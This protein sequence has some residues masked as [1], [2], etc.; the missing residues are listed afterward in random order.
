[1]NWTIIWVVWLIDIG[2]RSQI[3][4]WDLIYASV[5]IRSFSQA[6]VLRLCKF[7]LGSSIIPVI[8]LNIT[9]FHVYDQKRTLLN[10]LWGL[11]WLLR[12]PEGG[13][14]CA[15]LLESFLCMSIY[16]SIV[17]VIIKCY[18][19]MLASRCPKSA[20]RMIFSLHYG[21][22]NSPRDSSG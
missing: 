21:Y 14:I 10:F 13:H 3:S 20:T 16:A 15:S 19:W 18:Y 7:A 9:S 5:A 8:R 1:M 6:W 12:G 4:R 22:R 17:I 11:C 2:K